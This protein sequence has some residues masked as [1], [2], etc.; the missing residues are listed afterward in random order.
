VTYMIYIILTFIFIYICV[1]I[2]T[3][4]Y[5]QNPQC[6]NEESRSMY[7]LAV[8]VRVICWVAT[9][10]RLLKIIGLFCR[11]LSILQGSSA[12]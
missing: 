1:Y 7:C 2:Y 5:I 4:I 11:V 6:S 8:R 12:K 9:I 3:Y 10:S